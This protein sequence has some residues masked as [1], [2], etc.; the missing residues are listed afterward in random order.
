[1]FRIFSEYSTFLTLRRRNKIRATIRPIKSENRLAGSRLPA[2]GFRSQGKGLLFK[3]K[4]A[5]R[6]AENA[7]PAVFVADFAKDLGE[8]RR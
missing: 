4:S 6:P 8:K 7:G 3:L 1:M 5:A 2:T